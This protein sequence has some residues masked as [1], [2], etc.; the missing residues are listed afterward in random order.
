LRS[1]NKY[2]LKIHIVFFYIASS[3][4]KAQREETQ[5]GSPLTL[6]L[7]AA[8]AHMNVKYPK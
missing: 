5:E 3:I 2:A 4:N 8:P 1:R 7:E 6:L